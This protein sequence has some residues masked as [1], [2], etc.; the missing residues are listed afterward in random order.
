MGT[1]STGI[2]GGYCTK[3][4]AD[5]GAEVVKVEP[6]GGDWLRGWTASGADV[7]EGDDGALFQYLSSSKRSV[8]AD[9]S[10]PDD[11]TFVRD[12]VFRV[13]HASPRAPDV[14]LIRKLPFAHPLPSRA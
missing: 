14:L 4:L 10:R 12:L 11:V 5:A 9:P 1:G 6:P 2:A 13:A 7:R 8:V 3:H